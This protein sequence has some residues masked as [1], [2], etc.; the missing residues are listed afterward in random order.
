VEAQVYKNEDEIDLRELFQTIKKRK[1]MIYVITGVITL[2]AVV[3]AFVLVKPTYE[4]KAMIEIGKM[5]AGTKSEIPI[6]NIGDVK[7]K[8]T[9]LYGIASKKKREY[10]RVKSIA[11]SKKSK[12]IFFIVVGGRDNHSAIGRIDEVVHKLENDYAQKVKT[13]VDIQKELIALTQYDIAVSK[14]NLKDAQT[15]LK[16]YNTKFLN[17]T[18]KDAA[19]AGLYTIQI[20]QNQSRLQGL[21]SRISA[22][23]TKEFTLKLSISPLRITQTHIVGKVEVLDRP[24]KP[25][26]ALIVVVA[27]ITG[28]MFSIFLVF[29]L[30]FLRGLKEEK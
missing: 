27:L 6:D 30:S 17:I 23:K 8:L 28:F 3:Y 13:Y 14:K 7:E 29:F 24:V 11:V 18:N 25:K 21:Q 20:S 9:Y 1:K 12:S 2:L 19:L 22:L 5:N 26:K 10:P 4:V 16:G 15:T